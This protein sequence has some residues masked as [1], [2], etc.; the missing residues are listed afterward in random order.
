[1][2]KFHLTDPSGT[3]YSVGAGGHIL[4]T[5]QN[6]GGG[7]AP[8]ETPAL[9][10]ATG[11]LDMG[12][13]KVTNLGAPTAGGDAVTKTYA[14]GLLGTVVANPLVADLDDT[15]GLPAAVDDLPGDVLV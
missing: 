7:S 11:D 10:P 4:D 5:P 1:M 2:P 13:N 3:Q 14:D 6:D 15:D 8:A 12:S 9:N